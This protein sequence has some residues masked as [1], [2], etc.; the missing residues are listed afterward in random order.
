MA[1][2]NP[3][4]FSKLNERLDSRYKLLLEEVRD[5]LEKS[6]NQQYVELVGRM[7]TDAGDESIGHALADLELAAIDRHIREIR[8]IEAARARL[9]DGSFGTC[10]DCG[11]SIDFERLLAYPTAK[12]CLVC[13]QQHEKTFASEKIPKL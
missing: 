4:Q 2:L 10:L 1:A 8:D 7:P 3:T 12:R 9:K 13:Q 6:E 11:D 5:E